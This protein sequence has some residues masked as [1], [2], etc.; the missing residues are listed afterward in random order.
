MGNI[1]HVTWLCRDECQRCQGDPETWAWG[2]VGGRGCRAGVLGVHTVMP[3]PRGS[4]CMAGFEEK[5]G[6]DSF[7]FGASEHSIAEQSG[8][9]ADGRKGKSYEGRGDTSEGLG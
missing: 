2:P 7:L 6:G 8:G 9:G 4:H 1:G 3:W 5:A